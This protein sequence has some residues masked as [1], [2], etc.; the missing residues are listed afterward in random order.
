MN[1]FRCKTDLPRTTL[2][3]LQIL[4]N[5]FENSKPRQNIIRYG[6]VLPSPKAACITAT[7]MHMN[8]ANLLTEPVIIIRHRATTTIFNKHS[9]PWKHKTLCIFLF[10]FQRFSPRCLVINSGFNGPKLMKQIQLCVYLSF[11]WLLL[12]VATQHVTLTPDAASDQDPQNCSKCASAKRGFCLTSK[13]MI[14]N[15]TLLASHN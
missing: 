10:S 6:F 13:S 1:F 8:Q 14:I 15:S 9:R 7:F 2:D 4:W 11:I 12:C 5:L 3:N